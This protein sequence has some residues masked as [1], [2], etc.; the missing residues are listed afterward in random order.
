MFP[1]GGQS[2]IMA[3]TQAR[4]SW[5]REG[6]IAIVGGAIYGFSHTVSGHPLD[7]IKA[8]MQLDQR[9]RGL[10]A[11]RVASLM[12]RNDGL[13]AFWRGAIPPLWGSV[14]YRSAMMSSYEASFTFLDAVEPTSA[15]GSVLHSEL[16]GVR[17][18]VVASA[19][20]C[21]FFRALFEAPIEYS[22]VMRERAPCRDSIAPQAKRADRGSGPSSI[23]ARATRSRARPL[24]SP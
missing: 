15:V 6:Q 4:A 7:N 21:S 20:A 11:R 24:C 19:V 3:H 12:W 8:A 13:A 10:S 5:I 9:Y 16:A 1:G 14:V 2:E 23:A 18:L 17:P 22:K